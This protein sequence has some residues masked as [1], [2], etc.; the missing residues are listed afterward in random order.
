MDI[1]NLGSQGNEGS[2]KTPHARKS[3]KLKAV[4]GIGGLATLTGVGSTLAAQLTL[5]ND[6]NVEFGQGVAHTAAC[7]NLEHGGGFTISPHTAYDNSTGKFRLG[8]FDITGLNLTPQ[9]TGWEL[10]GSGEES[11]DQAHAKADHPGEYFDGSDWI[12]TCAGVVLNINA[13]TDSADYENLTLY[14]NISSPLFLID[15]RSHFSAGQYLAGAAFKFDDGETSYSWGGNPYQ[16]RDTIGW[17]DSDTG[18]WIDVNDDPRT[19]NATVHLIIDS[20][21]GTDSA[22]ISKITVESM[23]NFPGNYSVFDNNSW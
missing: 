13:Y 23:P 7:D 4:I 22:A 16:G 5:N 14:S 18:W 6:A 20:N 21:Y 19:D 17:E 2:P 12:P 9:G 1:L 10:T 3:K 8:G 11:Y 15:A